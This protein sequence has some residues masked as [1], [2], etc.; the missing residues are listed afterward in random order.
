MSRKRERIVANGAP[1]ISS[2]GLIRIAYIQFDTCLLDFVFR[3]RRR[4]FLAMHIVRCVRTTPF[5][6]HHVIDH[7][8]WASPARLSS[9]RAGTKL[10][11]PVRLLMFGLLRRVIGRL[12]TEKE[13]RECFPLP[14][15]SYVCS[16]NCPVR[17]SQAAWDPAILASRKPRRFPSPQ[18][19]VRSHPDFHV[20][21]GC[22]GFRW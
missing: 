8:A 10:L 7:V 12:R 18:K 5:Q 20:P 17:A 1:S 3:L 2:S 21:P 6:W 14:P 16:L 9:G 22:G 13:T 15:D 19:C 4:L 11:R